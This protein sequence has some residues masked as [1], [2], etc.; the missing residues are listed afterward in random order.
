MNHK[1]IQVVLEEL[2]YSGTIETQAAIN[3]IC[4]Y[5]ECVEAGDAEKHYKDCV[6]NSDD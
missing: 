5:I 4:N 6:L 1:H 2:S 3:D